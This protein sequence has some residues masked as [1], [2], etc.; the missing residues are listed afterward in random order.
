[1]TPTSILVVGGGT[2]GLISAII[3]KK[4]FDITV[5]VVHSTNV[6]IIGV[7]EGSTEHFRE[8]MEFAGIDYRAIISQCDATFKSGILFKD[9]G[10]KD[11]LHSVDGDF[12]LKIGQHSYIYANQIANNSPYLY[13]ENLLK[14]KINSDFL[15][16]KEMPFNQFHF[17]SFKLNSFLINFAKSIGVNIFEDDISNVVID[18]DGNISNLDGVKSNYKYDF[19]ID[20]TGFKRLLI[21]KLGAKWNSFSPWLKMK[22]AIV[23]P[24]EDEENYNLWTLAQAMD[25]GWMFRIPVWGRYGNGYIFDSDYISSDQAHME[26]NRYFNKEVEISKEFKFDP[27]ALEQ[28]WIKNCCAIG[29]SGSFVEPLE[30]SSIG[31]SIQQTFLLMHKLINYDA[32]TIKNYN[33]SFKD[34]MEN[35]RDFI[36]LH[37]ITKR[38]DT[39][40]WKDVS[41]VA[42]PDT[43]ATK[44]EIWKSRLPINE[45]FNNLSDYILFRADNHT[46]VLDG[47]DLF[48]RAKINQEVSLYS[49]SLKVSITNSIT[50]NEKFDK[51]TLNLNHKEFLNIIRNNIYRP[52]IS[53]KFIS[54]N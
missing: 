2:A 19:Y 42:L 6:G 12:N 52:A 27:G 35:I 14:N 17:N 31:T 37:Y 38:N 20:S 15:N 22:S 40:F 11:Y 43:L 10:E 53:R 3:L 51:K 16:S 30:A 25:Y 34:I 47:L 32:I 39:V 44:L 46:L 36:I 28:V 23:F 50:R 7:G 4:R 54:K 18:N 5:D 41:K 49:D 24:T 9:W 45:D 13:P 8:F 1:M 26:V 33:K 21:G 29:L 48:D